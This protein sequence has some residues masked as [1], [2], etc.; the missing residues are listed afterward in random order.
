MTEELNNFTFS[1]IRISIISELVWILSIIYYIIFSLI[2]NFVAI[3]SLD[4]LDVVGEKKSLVRS[5]S[6]GRGSSVFFEKPLA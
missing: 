4:I 6:R 5:V 1:S 3:E 2:N